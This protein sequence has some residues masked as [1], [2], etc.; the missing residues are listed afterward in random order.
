MADEA[1]LAGQ[2]VRRLVAGDGQGIWVLRRLLPQ[3]STPLGRPP[4]MPLQHRRYTAP[5]VEPSS[6]A[7]LDRRTPATATAPTIMNSPKSVNSPSSRR[8]RASQTRYCEALTVVQSA[9]L[10]PGVA[11]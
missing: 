11:T 1:I 9:S 7:A 8:K 3:G 5:A 4:G 6:D 2:C 10:S